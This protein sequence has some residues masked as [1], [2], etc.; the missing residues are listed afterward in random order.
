MLGRKYNNHSHSSSS[1]SSRFSPSHIQSLPPSGTSLTISGNDIRGRASLD[2]IASWDSDTPTLVEPRRT[3][4]PARIVTMSDEVAERRVS[5]GIGG[6]GN[7]RM[8]SHFLFLG[9][10][11][12]L[13]FTL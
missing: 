1:L 3:V 7:L 13:P 8:S 12:S 10:S 2:T 9:I 6:A 4:L 11:N 5:Y